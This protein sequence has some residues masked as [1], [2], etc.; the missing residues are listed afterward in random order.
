MN[1][2]SKLLAEARNNPG[3]LSFSDFESLMN[4]AGWRF[5]RQRGSHRIWYSPERLMLSVQPRRNKAKSYQVR[6]FLQIYE[7]ET[8][9]G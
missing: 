8:S 5:D 6:Q 7:K 2:L 3:G 4:Q 1:K 9:S